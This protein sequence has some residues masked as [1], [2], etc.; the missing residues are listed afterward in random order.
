MLCLK[1]ATRKD[2]FQ[3]PCGQC[4]NCKVNHRR[5]WVAR[6]LLESCTHAY[7]VFVTLTFRDTGTPAFLR[8]SDLK[9]FYRN[10]RH[11]LPE[12]RHFSVGEYGTRTG[13]AHYHA[14]I[15]S[16]SRPVDLRD[17][18]KAWPYGS[19][20]LGQTE[21]DSIQYVFGYLFKSKK[22]RWPI[23]V[24]YPE[25]RCF[26]QGIGRGAYLELSSAGVLPREF[27]VLGQTFPVS[28]YFRSIARRDGLL[29]DETKA[30]KLERLETAQM[31]ALLD[32]PSLSQEQKLSLYDEALKRRIAKAQKLKEKAIRDAYLQM[33]GHVKLR[34]KNETL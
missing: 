31:C 18:Q 1:M 32:L 3:F 6:L 17:L 29:V 19:V 12:V 10:L 16:N 15:F 27:Q 25:L 28:R 8:R 26:S 24:R 33:H 13:R 5:N 23:E 22:D 9:Y 4:L 2:G 21:A 11:D 30:I 20:H 34:S 14:H 7:S